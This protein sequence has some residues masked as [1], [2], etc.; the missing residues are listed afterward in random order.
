MAKYAS[1]LFVL[2]TSAFCQKP[3]GANAAQGQ[4]EHRIQSISLITSEDLRK[5]TTAYIGKVRPEV[6]AI[7]LMAVKSAS[8][9]ASRMPVM[10]PSKPPLKG[11][12]IKAMPVC[13]E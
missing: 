10:R 13:G 2:S 3:D 12:V 7:G 11:D 8:A 4:L 1:L 9:Y 5:P 6:C